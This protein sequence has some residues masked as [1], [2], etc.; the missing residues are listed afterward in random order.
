[1]HA[2][3]RRIGFE[4][5]RGNRIPEPG[6]WTRFVGSGKVEVTLEVMKWGSP[7]WMDDSPK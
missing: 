4:P 7:T 2:D 5:R 6:A 3:Q 1:M